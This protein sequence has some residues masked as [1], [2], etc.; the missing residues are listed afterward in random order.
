[1]N[2]RNQYLLELAK[3]NVKAYIANPKTKAAMVAGSVAEELCD[4]YSDC[5]VS[6]YDDELPSEEELQLARQQNQGS[7]RLWILGDRRSCSSLASLIAANKSCKELV[8]LAVTKSVL[9]RGLG[10][11]T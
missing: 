1:M 10:D 11:A 2:D 4:E 6:I 9:D 3:R 8:M 7:E 5:D